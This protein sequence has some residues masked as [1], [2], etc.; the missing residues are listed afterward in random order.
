M[1]WFRI[2]VCVNEIMLFVIFLT[3]QIYAVCGQ[4]F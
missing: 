4:K 1:F 2:S 3:L